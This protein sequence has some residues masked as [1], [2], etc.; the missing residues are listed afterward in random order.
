MAAGRCASTDKHL[1][2]NR[3][4]ALKGTS[5]VE[6]E[7]LDVALAVDS[8]WMTT[9]LS[10]CSSLS[11]DRMAGSTTF[12]LFLMQRFVEWY[13]SLVVLYTKRKFTQKNH[14]EAERSKIKETLVGKGEEE[15]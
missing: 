14:A 7:K 5:I 12:T 11:S 6:G 10:I 4:I 13:I 9:S 3:V 1:E 15:E 2:L 8:W